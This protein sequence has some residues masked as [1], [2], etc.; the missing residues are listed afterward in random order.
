MH[1]QVSELTFRTPGEGFTNI[2][3]LEE[4]KVVVPVEVL[5]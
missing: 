1:Q 2:T 3:G 5:D 4:F